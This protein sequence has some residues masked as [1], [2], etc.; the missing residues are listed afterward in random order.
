VR[1]VRSGVPAACAPAPRP[2]WLPDRYVLALGALEPRKDRRPSSRRTRWR[3][4]AGST[5]TSSSPA[6]G[7]SPRRS[8]PPACTSPAPPTAR[9][10]AAVRR[11]ARARGPARHEGFGFAPLEAALAGTPSVVA[12]L[13]VYDET[14]GPAALRAPA[15]DAEAWADALMRITTDTALAQRAGDGG[16]RAGAPTELGARGARAARRARGGR[17]R[18]RARVTSFDVVVVIHDSAAELTRLLES[19]D[20]HA[21]GEARVV[22][23]DTGSVDDGAE[24]ARE[25]AA[26][27]VELPDNPGFGAAK[28]AGVARARHDVVALLNPDVELLDDGLLASPTAPAPTDALLFPAPQPRRHG[29][30]LRSPRPRAGAGAAP[31]ARSKGLWPKTLRELRARSTV[32]DRSVQWDGP[33]R[34][35]SFARTRF[36]F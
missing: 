26:E 16:R 3:A 22:V 10:S 8:A 35:P 20:R 23:V 18:R 14:L 32:R 2:D 36:L 19:I 11:R 28:H 24:R 29:P 27:F 15:G 12:D 17:G 25:W 7:A 34:E 4:S 5:P 1:V 6:T 9:S 31:R 33:Q 30:G 13:S 21:R